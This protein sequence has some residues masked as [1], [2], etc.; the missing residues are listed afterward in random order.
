MSYTHRIERLPHVLAST[1]QTV[2]KVSQP[3]TTRP[4]ASIV[5]Q[6][7]RQG[8][9]PGSGGGPSCYSKPGSKR[10]RLDSCNKASCATLPSGQHRRDNGRK[11]GR[12]HGQTRWLGHF[13]AWRITSSDRH[14]SGRRCGCRSR[15]GTK[16]VECTDWKVISKGITSNLHQD[17]VTRFVVVGMWRKVRIEDNHLCVRDES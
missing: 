14:I 8:G 5:V 6:L 1:L 9:H 4:L 17:C 15:E 7:E 10:H 12:K 11:P 13:G 16:L 2:K 3:D